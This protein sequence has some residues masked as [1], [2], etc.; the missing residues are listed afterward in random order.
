MNL[1]NTQSEM[2]KILENVVNI[3]SGSYD[4]KGVDSFGSYLQTL[5]S[6]IGFQTK[7]ISNENLGNNLILKHQDAEGPEILVLAHMDTVFKKGTAKERPFTVKGGYAFGPGV[8]DMKASHVMLY[9]ALKALVE[10]DNDTYK[11]VVLLFNSDEEIGSKSSKNLIKEMSEDKKY[12]LVLEPA[13]ADGSI[14][15]SRRGSSHYHLKIS[16]VAAHSGIEP[17]KGCSAIKEMAHKIFK[18]EALSKPEEGLHVSVV[19]I[20]G[21]KASNIISP[22][23]E[24]T[25]DVR[26]S[27]QEQGEWVDTQ[28]NKIVKDADIDGTTIELSGGLNRPPMEYTSGTEKLVRL[29]QE[30]AEKLGLEVDHTATGG[31]SDGSFP[32]SMGV[33]TVDGL[34]PVGGGQHSDDEYLEIQTLPERAELFIEVLKNIKKLE[35]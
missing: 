8:I 31:G 7:I 21:G 12:A 23:A 26:I 24:A 11:N 2:L 35:G 17:D 10:E 27:T 13:R 20:S 16:G 1:K 9:S 22:N 33:D 3:D 34:G 30:E 6:T 15:S 32:S 4:K 5:Y 29:I 28:I 14:V 19:E 18:I 25:V